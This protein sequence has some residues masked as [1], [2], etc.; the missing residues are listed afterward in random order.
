[1]NQLGETFY[2]AEDPELGRIVIA[3][4]EGLVA[5]KP[6]RGDVNV[7]WAW[8]GTRDFISRYVE[9]AT[10]KPDLSLACSKRLLN[11][12]TEAGLDAMLLPLGACSHYKPLHLHREG[13]GYV[14]GDNKSP[15]QKRLM[16]SPFIGRSDFEWHGRR[17]S[18]E[19]FNEE[20]L[21]EWYNRKKIVFGMSNFNCEYWHQISNRT[22]E[23]YG[24]G[25]PLIFPRH[26][27]FEET[28]GFPQPYPVDKE[29]DVEGWVKVMQK[30]YPKTLETFETLS[31]IIHE[32]HSFCDRW[33]RLVARLKEMQK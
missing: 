18:D 2:A 29:G 9:N 24:S 25:T 33:N 32:H 10:V 19:W 7:W 27:A 22:F 3:F 15:E 1:M 14:G 28:F 26:P 17:A 4:G 30:D 21:N 13:F 8:G 11:G 23:T 5:Q 20:K 31:I 6:Y 12:L 16:L